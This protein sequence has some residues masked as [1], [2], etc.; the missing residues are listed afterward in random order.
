MQHASGKDY[1][2]S[3]WAKQRQERIKRALQARQKRQSGSPDK[4]HTFKPQLLSSTDG[5]RSKLPPGARV[6]DA[7]ATQGAYDLTVLDNMDGA[8]P[9]KRTSANIYRDNRYDKADGGA[10]GPMDFGETRDSLDRL[11][12][13]TSDGDRQRLARMGSTSSHSSAVAPPPLPSPTK[14]ESMEDNTG[15]EHTHRP[16]APRAGEEAGLGGRR[17]RVR[18]DPGGRWTG[19]TREAAAAQNGGAYGEYDP[20]TKHGLGDAFNGGGGSRRPAAAATGDDALSHELEQRSHVRGAIAEEHRPGQPRHGGDDRSG[21]AVG[22]GGPVHAGGAEAAATRR[23]SGGV[24]CENEDPHSAEARDP[25]ERPEDAD[26]LASLRGG[27]GAETGANRRG[28]GSRVAPGRQAARARHARR[29]E[30]NSDTGAAAS[31]GSPRAAVVT[32]NSP[33]AVQG[34]IEASSTRRRNTDGTIGSIADSP[35]AAGGGTIGGSNGTAAN[36]GGNATWKH[37]HT[38][39]LPWGDEEGALGGADVVGGE[40]DGDGDGGR[41]LYGFG[42]P[43]ASQLARK[44]A[45]EG[46][47]GAPRSGYR[48]Q[49]MMPSPST[50][51]LT[52]AYRGGDDRF[53][54]ADEGV[55]P[56]VERGVPAEKEQLRRN[57]SLLKKKMHG[58]AGSRRSQ[59]AGPR[60]GDLFG[61]PN[62]APSGPGG[63]DSHPAGG[64]R[65]HLHMTTGTAPAMMPA[66]PGAFL[67]D[68]DAAGRALG[69]RG[70][71][72]GA[73]RRPPPDG[74]GSPYA[75]DPNPRGA[76][77]AAAAR[78]SAR[79]HQHRQPPL[80]QQNRQHQ[81]RQQHASIGGRRHGPFEGNH[82]SPRNT[83]GRAAVP[84]DVVRSRPHDHSDTREGGGIG[85]ARRA[86]PGRAGGGRPRGGGAPGGQ[87]SP[88][89]RRAWEGENGGGGSQGD[90][91]SRGGGGSRGGGDS[92]GKGGGGR[93]GGGQGYADDLPPDAFPD[94]Q[95]ELKECRMCGRRFT[96]AALEKHSRAC[97]KVF[98]AKRKVFDT[99]EMRLKG[100]E[101]EKFAKEKGR[102]GGGGRQGGR[103]GRGG[104]GR[105]RGGKGP[106]RG[107]DDTPVG[108]A[109]S[110]GAKSSKWRQQSK[111]FRDALRQARVVTD[112]QKS[113]KSL[114]DL[115]P[116]KPSAPDPSLI[117][118]PHCG[119]RFSELAG[120][121]HMQHCKNIKAKPS[122][123]KKGSGS[124]LGQAARKTASGASGASGRG[125]GQRW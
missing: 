10:R 71:G 44:G 39:T 28:G 54:G 84:T 96:P 1:D 37:K 97:H 118:C 95:V 99:A 50:G 122:V 8:F 68:R 17:R 46:R 109:A 75:I 25:I 115:P 86:A 81:H 41:D 18:E 114:A 2:P 67:R 48:T 58:Q 104:G 100:T 106:P 19:P 42:R 35:Y 105:G 64:G 3:V 45:D 53:G 87:G 102:A 33:S 30:W 4:N 113:G 61:D 32:D 125:R 24:T 63:A 111:Q 9:P 91:S 52:A 110:R 29:P 83:G 94:E 49:Q 90:G 31:L 73:R 20:A 82:D 123:L 51:N 13:S 74:P 89:R 15:S 34:R 43:T 57:L 56:P 101:L 124:L 11:A 121:R 55:D 27:E 76:A 77:A 62:A 40:D 5:A 7:S 117:P 6:G 66:D 78:S 65:Q 80:E 119:R 38:K 47:G 12:V 79:Q 23:N 98:Q 93:G 88:D 85:Y 26:F 92:R 69:R 107:F 22:N 112:A 120:E 36:G 16:H 60:A 108:G 21:R 70:V 14:S 72:G 103:G 59:S 116:P